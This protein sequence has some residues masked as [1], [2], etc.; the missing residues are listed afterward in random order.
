MLN[1]NHIG[2]FRNL[3]NSNSFYILHK[4]RNQ[5]GKNKWN[6]ICSAMDWI[7]VSVDNYNSYNLERT[8]D[9]NK[10][11]MD[12]YY[13]ISLIDIITESI[14]QLHRVLTGSLNTP[15]KGE[16]IIF[17]NNDQKDD[18]EYFKHIR[19]IFG[20]HPVNLNKN[21]ER[22]YASWPFKSHFGDYDLEVFLYP[23]NTDRDSMRFGIYIEELKRYAE[24]RYN[25]LL[26]LKNLI[27]KDYA[28]YIEKCKNRTINF[29]GNNLSVAL[30][31]KKEHI[32]RLPNDYIDM[33]IDDVIEYLGVEITNSIN[34]ELYFEF[35]QKVNKVLEDLKVAVQSL[36]YEE[37]E[38][39]GLLDYDFPVNYT[40]EFSKYFEYLG[41]KFDSLSDYFFSVIKEYLKNIVE[42]DS[43][44]SNEEQKLLIVAAL[45][46]I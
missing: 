25:Y 36:D 24:R 45:Q 7:T 17:N 19:A 16:K 31:L 21:N 35:M 20:A 23:L 8:K 4:F 10:Y 43:T 1:E 33:M 9:I 22:W 32:H 5:E 38:S 41:G 27:N 3:V 40:Y 6:I 39:Y 15:F 18:D 42:I 46:K 2:G 29:K 44:M 26:K 34:E 14:N 30:L 13:Y 12:V 28:N 11:C 37:R